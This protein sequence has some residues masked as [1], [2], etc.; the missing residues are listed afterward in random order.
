MDNISSLTLLII[1]IPAYLP[2][3]PHLPFSSHP[4]LKQLKLALFRR[5]VTYFLHRHLSLAEKCWKDT[6]VA[7]VMGNGLF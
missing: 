5:V 4:P 3:H 7:I 2:P 6:L 1:S